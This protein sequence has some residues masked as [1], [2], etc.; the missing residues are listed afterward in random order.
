[1]HVEWREDLK[2]SLKAMDAPTAV[3]SDIVITSR[4]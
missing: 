4:G 1:M 2:D 3:V